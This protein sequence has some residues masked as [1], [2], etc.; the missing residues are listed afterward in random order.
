MQ[1]YT[2]AEFVFVFFFRILIN[3]LFLYLKEIDNNNLAYMRVLLRHKIYRIYVLYYYSL[4][5][6]KRAL[7]F[8]IQIFNVLFLV[9]KK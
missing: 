9:Y 1:V 7:Q 3:F 2:V 5:A 4:H 8:I 6:K